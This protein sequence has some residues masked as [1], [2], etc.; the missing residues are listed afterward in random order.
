MRGPERLA[1]LTPG[2][3]AVKPATMSRALSRRLQGGLF[4]GALSLVAPTVIA[5]S[6]VAVVDTQRAVMETEDGLRMQA[7]LKK[8]FDQRQQEIDQKQNDLQR[9]REELEKQR[10]VLSQ[11]VLRQR[12]EKWQAE[13]MQVQ[14]RFGEYNK[15][16][17]SKQ[18]ELMQPILAKALEVVRRIATEQGYAVVVDKQAVPY[19]RADLDLT[20]RVIRDIILGAPRLQPPR[21]HLRLPLLRRP[22]RP[23]RR[24][25][26]A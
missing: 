9:E 4:L 5:D 12:A 21:L 20:D 3:P 19:A 11:E 26:K 18:N 1:V 17:Q 14:Q 8:I 10:T 16:L 7:S 22:H 15:E 6:Q 24:A 13:M 23:R 2:E 25:S